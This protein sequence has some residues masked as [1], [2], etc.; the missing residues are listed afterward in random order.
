MRI[1]DSLFMESGKDGG[2]ESKVFGT[3]F[4]RIKWL[5]TAALLC[6]HKGSREAYH[7]HAFNSI[8]WVLRGSLEEHTLHLFG[9]DVVRTYLPSW[10][11]VI[12]RRNTFHK[13]YGQGEK[14]WVLTF[15][16]PWDGNW[17]EFVYQDEPHTGKLTFLTHDR[18]VIDSAVVKYVLPKVDD[19]QAA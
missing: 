6:F 17:S 16:G 12:T 8:S 15:R 4:V 3:W 18:K 5:F 1:G 7:T 13:V 10:K 19:T 2:P 9:K 14:T 11:P